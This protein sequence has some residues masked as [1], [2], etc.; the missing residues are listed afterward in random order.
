VA[1]WE[2]VAVG[3]SVGVR[4]GL[5]LSVRVTSTDVVADNASEEDFDDGRLVVV[6]SSDVAVNDNVEAVGAGVTVRDFDAV[7][8]AVSV[9]AGVGA[10]AT[11]P[12]AKKMAVNA[13]MASLIIF[14]RVLFFFRD[15]N[16]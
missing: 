11:H 16:G 15:Q 3:V 8:A 4:V 9:G 10:G 2:N 6:V 5:M 14:L 7:S 13:K 12:A 1:L